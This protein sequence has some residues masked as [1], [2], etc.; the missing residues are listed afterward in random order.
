MGPGRRSQGLRGGL[1]DLLLVA[2]PAGSAV[3]DA[4]SGAA[5][6]LALA[7]PRQRLTA[8][9]DSCSCGWGQAGRGEEGFA[10]RA[11]QAAAG[12]PGLEL[13]G[14]V[15]VWL[16]TTV[17]TGTWRQRADLGTVTLSSCTEGVP[18]RYRGACVGL[19]LNTGARAAPPRGPDSWPPPRPGGRRDTEARG[20]GAALKGSA[21]SSSL[22][23][24]DEEEME[25]AA[26]QKL[27][28]Q[29][30]K[31]VAEVSP[32]SAANVSVAA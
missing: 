7:A 10:F 3:L 24:Q 27:A 13:G 9:C 32:V 31:E 4:G 6:P 30:A 15:R 18:G 20:A 29:K 12:S 1:L 21:S 19:A 16:P 25:E 23:K 17:G 2:V 22:S 11:V 5:L 8:R 14:G 28:L 26:N